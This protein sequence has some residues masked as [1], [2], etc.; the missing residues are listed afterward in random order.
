MGSGY[1]S[2]ETTH[3]CRGYSNK[4]MCLSHDPIADVCLCT[5]CLR[6]CR[7]NVYR[8]GIELEYPPHSYDDNRTLYRFSLLI[9]TYHEKGSN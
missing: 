4:V 5:L 9:F 2:G 6:C 3:C 8:T 1:G 7:Y